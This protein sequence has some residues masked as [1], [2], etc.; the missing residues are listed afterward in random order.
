MGLIEITSRT[1]RMTALLL[2]AQVSLGF[3]R[4]P[5]LARGGSP[6]RPARARMLTGHTVIGLAL[7][8]LAFAHAWSSMKL[9]GIRQQERC[10]RDPQFLNE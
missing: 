4:V 3:F 8:S 5:A 6:V 1:A 7:P 10:C 2:G 9:P